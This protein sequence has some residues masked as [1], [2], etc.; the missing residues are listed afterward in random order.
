[1]VLD[2]GDNFGLVT[3][4][5]GLLANNGREGFYDLVTD[6]VVFGFECFFGH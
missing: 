2:G 5:C 1:M 4:C 3:D 6:R